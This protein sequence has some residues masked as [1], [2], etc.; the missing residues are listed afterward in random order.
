MLAILDLDYHGTILAITARRPSDL[1]SPQAEPLVRVLRDEWEQLDEGW[2]ELNASGNGGEFGAAPTPEL[3]ARCSPQ[4]ARQIMIRSD[5]SWLNWMRTGLDN[6]RALL[7]PREKR[8]G[9]LLSGWFGSARR[10]PEDP[11]SESADPHA[12]GSLDSKTPMS[13]FCALDPDDEAG[14]PHYIPSLQ[15]D[16]TTAIAEAKR[17]LEG[18]ERLINSH[19]SPTL[20]PAIMADLN[21]P[22]LRAVLGAGPAWP[23]T[24]K[25]IINAERQHLDRL[26]KVSARHTNPIE[27][28]GFA[29]DPKGD[30]WRPPSTFLALDG[31]TEEAARRQAILAR[32]RLGPGASPSQWHSELIEAL[33]PWLR[34][35]PEARLVSVNIFAAAAPF[36]SQGGA[37]L[38]VGVP[39]PRGGNTKASPQELRI[40]MTVSGTAPLTVVAGFRPHGS[41][42]VSALELLT[43]WKRG[44]KLP[45]LA[46]GLRL[47]RAWAEIAPLRPWS[48]VLASLQ[49]PTSGTLRELAGHLAEVGRL[50]PTRTA[51]LARV[52]PDILR[53]SPWT[54]RLDLARSVFL[55]FPEHGR[56]QLGLPAIQAVLA[57]RPSGRPTLGDL[58]HV[59]VL[60]GAAGVDSP[61]LKVAEFCLDLALK[62]GTTESL[63]E[64]LLTWMGALPGS[65]TAAR[66]AV[67][68]DLALIC[69]RCLAQGGHQGLTRRRVIG[70]EVQKLFA[71]CEPAMHGK[72][73]VA[74]SDQLCDSAPSQLPHRWSDPS[75]LPDAADWLQALPALCQ[76]ARAWNIP[77]WQ[78]E[79]LKETWCRLGEG[80]PGSVP[81]LAPGCFYAALKLWLRSG[82]A[83]AD[84]SEMRDLGSHAA[85]YRFQQWLSDSDPD[86]ALQAAEQYG[87]WVRTQPQ[88]IPWSDLTR[89]WLFLCSTCQG[90]DGKPAD[91][92]WKQ[93]IL[94]FTRWGRLT[95]THQWLLDLGSLMPWTRPAWH[96]ALIAFVQ[97][98]KGAFPVDAVALVVDQLFADGPESPTLGAKE[99]LDKDRKNAWARDREVWVKLLDA[100]PLTESTQRSS[101]A[102]VIETRAARASSRT[103]REA[104]DATEQ[105]LALLAPRMLRPP[106]AASFASWSEFLPPKPAPRRF[107]LLSGLLVRALNTAGP[108]PFSERVDVCWEPLAITAFASTAP[109]TGLSALLALTESTLR[110]GAFGR[111][112]PTSIGDLK[113]RAALRLLHDLICIKDDKGAFDQCIRLLEELPEAA[114]LLA[115]HAAFLDRLVHWAWNQPDRSTRLD[116]LAKLTRSALP[117]PILL[118]LA[119]AVLQRVQLEKIALDLLAGLRPTTL[120]AWQELMKLPE[121][122]HRRALT[123]TLFLTP[124]ARLSEVWRR[125]VALEYVG[126][127]AAEPDS[128]S[129]LNGLLKLL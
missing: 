4:A 10:P 43:M 44:K 129:R 83:P 40:E 60:A 117:E 66:D 23:A 97:D 62:F 56:R 48:L 31:L 77:K 27:D 84:S 116:K 79:G 94:I 25:E 103:T 105:A 55:A 26:E 78:P 1:R 104:I 63:V 9:T 81:S 101:V 70:T 115:G 47:A 3:L 38:E 112:S 120:P 124:L 82:H 69:Q 126:L 6:D 71:I 35:L 54:G 32:E 28:R 68:A 24:L 95:H 88:F 99:F 122:P 65:P 72:L 41:P 106:E 59:V 11:I 86:R 87:R 8:S 30:L 127:A 36:S 100:F 73:L 13:A 128:A 45:G 21:G 67:T 29:G 110:A 15:K 22:S 102:E 80:M 58:A 93:G 96:A 118:S 46:A 64:D 98:E 39:L 85:L 123:R 53:L 50:D 51:G 111:T 119:Q 5:G 34:R 91:S 121:S 109:K 107:S 61:A 108:D 57:K 92:V 114:P 89:E 16:R 42:S 37:L 90:G 76:L 74:I 7:W 20:P 33:D 12:Q 17:K 19:P 49:S 14:S 2:K 113:T 75:D 18:L 125:H 52:L